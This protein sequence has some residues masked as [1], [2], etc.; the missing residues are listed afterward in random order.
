MGTCDLIVALKENVVYV[1]RNGSL[2]E[3]PAVKYKEW[4]DKHQYDPEHGK[5]LPVA[6][7][8]QPKPS[9]TPVESGTS[10]PR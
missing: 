7:A 6:P 9:Q 4:M 2:V 8:P 3:E 1:R 5:N 10:A